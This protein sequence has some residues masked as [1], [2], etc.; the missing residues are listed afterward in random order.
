MLQAKLSPQGLGGIR[1]DHG[2]LRA[3]HLRDS[4]L[5]NLSTIPAWEKRLSKNVYIYR[6]GQEKFL[7]TTSVGKFLCQ[8]ALRA[9]PSG[10][11]VVST[12][13][14][15]RLHISS[16]WSLAP[17][18]HCDTS[19][20]TSGPTSAC[21]SPAALTPADPTLPEAQP[22]GSPAQKAAEGMFHAVIWDVPAPLHC[23]PQAPSSRRSCPAHLYPCPVPGTAPSS[24][25]DTSQPKET[26]EAH[27]PARR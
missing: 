15:R 22:L 1:Y 9:K 4:S 19:L 5:F 6:R 17:A 14:P 8:A 2:Q 3:D 26:P 12:S 23:P 7:E 16:V 11:G 13:P 18:Q 25:P 24:P 10:L 20:A 21:P 27:A